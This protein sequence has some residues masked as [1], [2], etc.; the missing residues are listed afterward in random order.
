MLF[1]DFDIDRPDHFFVRSGNIQYTASLK[2]EIFILIHLPW[3]HDGN[4]PAYEVFVEIHKLTVKSE[5]KKEI[6][7]SVVKRILTLKALN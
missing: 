5:V 2:K 4:C 6:L 1:T 7:L 3:H